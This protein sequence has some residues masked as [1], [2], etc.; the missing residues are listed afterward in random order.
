MDRRAWIAGLSLSFLG[1]CN[2]VDGACWLKKDDNAG[3]GA[4][5]SPIVPS[6]GSFG[7]APGPKPQGAGDPQPGD[8]PPPPECLQVPQGKCYEKCLSDYTD[9]SEKCGKI[10]SESQRLVCQ[11]SA[12]QA[13]KVCRAACL[14]AENDCLDHCKDLCVDIWE[15]CYDKCKGNNTCGEKCM[16]ELIAC[17][18]KCE[19]KCK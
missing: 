4:G 10:E 3:S 16:R 19:E 1:A 15:G 9:T 2:W 13:Y 17:N 8:P 18:E 6:G 14:K 7:D 11:E 5:G 12:Y